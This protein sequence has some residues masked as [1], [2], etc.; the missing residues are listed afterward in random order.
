MR[1]HLEQSEWSDVQAI[2]D[3][4][5]AAADPVTLAMS[6]NIQHQGDIAETSGLN[7]TT[8]RKIRQGGRIT[9]AQRAALKYAI[10]HRMLNL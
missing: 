9:K 3:D 4:M 7:T 10:L 5:D 1:I 6:K 8:L 2:L